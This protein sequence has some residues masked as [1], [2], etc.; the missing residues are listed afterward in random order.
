MGRVARAE[1]PWLLLLCGAWHPAGAQTTQSLILG[2]I[3]DAVTGQSIQVAAITCTDEATNLTSR[4]EVDPRGNYAI[5]S[6]SPGRYT[7]TVSAS[8]YQTQQVR[9]LELPVAGRVELNLR[10]RPLSDVWE[11]GQYRSWLLPESQQAL[12]FYGP[13]VDTSRVAV[14]NANRGLTTP[15]EN[16]R[17]DVISSVSIQDLPLIGRDVYTMLLLLPGVTSD[18]ATA[19]GLGFSVNGQRP[20]SSNYL[21]DGIENNNLLVTGPLSAAI[22]EFIQEYRVSTT[23]YSAEYG[24]T[25]GFVANAITRS[26]TNQWHGKGFFYFENDRLNASGFQENAHG[27]PRNAFTQIQPGVYVSGPI[28]PNRLFFSGGFQIVRS[29]GRGDPQPFALP[30]TSFVQS[31]DPASYVGQL[32]RRHSAE[33]LP[34]GPGD[35][36]IVS[37]APVAMVSK[38]DG[39][40]RADYSLSPAH[41]LFSRVAIDGIVQ[42]ELLFNPYRDFSTSYRQQSISVAAGLS[43]RLGSASQNELRAG[44]SGDAV[45]LQTPHA[46]IPSLIDQERIGASAQ[47]YQVLLPGNPSAYDYRNRGR[48]WEVLDNWTWTAGRH[49][50][51]SGAGLLQRG[52]DLHLSVYPRGYLEFAN[53]SDFAQNKLAFLTAQFDRRSSTRQPVSP[54]RSY[55]YGQ[56]FAFAQDSFHLSDRFTMD[57][58][59][60]FEYF[61]SPVNTGSTK[62]LL[63]QLNRSRDIRTALRNLVPALPSGVADQPVYTSRSSNWAVRAGLAWDPTGKGRTLVR[64]S[65]GIFYDRLF[66]NLWENVIQNRYQTAVWKFDQPVPLT[67]SLNQLEKAGQYQSSSE[68][69]HGL[70]FQ[71]DLRAPRTQGAFVGIQQI[72][73]PG[74]TVEIDGLASRARQL[75]TTDSVNRPFSEP[76]SLGNDFGYLYPGFPD[77]I[78]YR[79]NEGSS[80]YTALVA[81]LRFS[82]THLSGQVSYSWSHS[83]DNQ[84][85]SLAGTFFDFNTFSAAQQTGHPFISSFTRQFASGLDRGNSDFDQRHNL[86]FFGS[87]QASPAGHGPLSRLSRNWTVAALGALRSG[88]PFTVYSDATYTKYPPEY[89]VN[90]RANV[91]APKSVNMSQPTLG[92]R[93]LLNAGAFQNP[94]PNVIGTGGRNAFAGPGLF[95]MDG[96]IARTFRLPVETEALRLTFRADFYNLLNHANLNNPASYYGAAD[97]GIA[98][99]GRREANSAFPLLAPLNETA[100]QIQILLRLEF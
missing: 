38:S 35:S 55:R 64:A 61:G 79:A 31:T 25:S 52:I 20:S 67:T 36:A 80:N 47:R 85:E 73:A 50:L 22:P 7:L 91:I 74:V 39:M 3:S 46:E 77:Y 62:D 60:R 97:F 99:Y 78:N 87:Y 69:I 89:F 27:I 17:S 29:H 93:L 82:K 100:R 86:V 37:I 75:L 26:G 14:F 11:A 18:T 42:P 21:L 53:L 24:R 12:G 1:C 56:Y 54:D 88:L 92:G 51:K 96:S 65:Y 57:Y 76:T 84:S 98:L 90:Q 30:T 44:R 28:L 10:I 8:Q 16:S 83:I 4:A 2:R 9:G 63:L 34:A 13:D 58:G 81:A 70:A 19:R 48:T 59:V 71:P 95:N 23:N 49:V 68:L 15:L 5:A 40:T 32:L 72:L 94:G 33:S 66:D 6:L 41:R 43:S 45:R